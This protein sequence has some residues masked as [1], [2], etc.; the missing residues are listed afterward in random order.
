MTDRS[1]EHFEEALLLLL[2]A[3][4]E[5]SKMWN[6]EILG[7]DMYHMIHWFFVY[8]MLGWLVE[9][10]YISICEKKVVNRGFVKGPIC[11]IY[12][13]GALTVYFALK[14]FEG[15]YVLL[16]FLGSFLATML[17]YL[18]A[19][20]M[21]SIFG[22]VWWDYNE[23]PFNYKGVLCLES[24]IAWGFYTIGLFL[25]LQRLII[26]IV[27]S[28]S[29]R[30]GKIAG[31]IFIIIFIVDFGIQMYKAKTNRIPRS[32]KRVSNAI[33]DILS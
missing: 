1:K 8:S 18:T 7:I 19:R 25:F 14:R 12:G 16:F 24:S 23:K 27:S 28:Y 15:N 21:S 10:I 4:K 20:I 11:P 13:M 17:E 30:D 6:R 31:Y 33:R 2:R 5:D 22:E 26:R 9:S 29:I 3:T 32:I